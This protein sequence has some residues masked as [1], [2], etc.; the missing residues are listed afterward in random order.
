[1]KRTSKIILTLACIFL[2]A[3]I[4]TVMITGAIIIKNG[5]IP[6]IIYSNNFESGD[7]NM[8]TNQTVDIENQDIK[9]I[10][11]T[12]NYGKVEFIKGDRFAYEVIGTEVDSSMF[13]HDVTGDTWYINIKNRS[14]FY[15]FGFGKDDHI[16]LL[17]ITVPN[18]EVLNGVNVKLNAGSVQVER[19]AAKSLSME[20]GAGSLEADELVG[21]ENLRLTVSA[22]KCKIDHMIG[23]NPYFRCEAGQIQAKGI[24]TGNGSVNCGVGHIDLDLIGDISEYDY[25]VSCSVGAIKINGNQVG[26]LATKNS[27]QTGLTNNFDLD[28]GVG[29]INLDFIPK[30]N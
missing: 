13:T 23:K 16:S 28:C 26:G 17:R 3:G 15:F 27:K 8:T 29:Q 9:N 19:L 22:G 5:N 10:T 7:N 24:L 4:L 11:L 14:G 1:M 20:M 21:E 18:T 30:E 25:G 2:T 12:G 6:E